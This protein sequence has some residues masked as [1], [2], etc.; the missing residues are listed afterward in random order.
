MFV[1]FM[2]WLV[3]YPLFSRICCSLSKSFVTIFERAAELDE[4]AKH[5]TLSTYYHH[6]HQIRN[7]VGQGEELQLADVLMKKET[8]GGIQGKGHKFT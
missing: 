3:A 1:L 7:E 4:D 2:G 5:P 6:Y 8:G